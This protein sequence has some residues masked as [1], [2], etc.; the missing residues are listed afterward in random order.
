MARD[1]PRLDLHLQNGVIGILQRAGYCC[2]SCVGLFLLLTLIS[3]LYEGAVEKY[4]LL[5]GLT[6]SSSSNASSALHYSLEVKFAS[7]APHQG[8]LP[9]EQSN[10]AKIGKGDKNRY[11]FSRYASFFS[12]G[13]SPHNVSGLQQSAV[14]EG[15]EFAS[16]ESL[17]PALSAD[18]SSGDDP[19]LRNAGSDVSNEISKDQAHAPIYEEDLTTEAGRDMLDGPSTEQRH[20]SVEGPQEAEVKVEVAEDTLYN[21]ALVEIPLPALKL[22][23]V[24]NGTKNSS[25]SILEE[26]EF[27][28]FSSPRLL[29]RRALDRGAMPHMGLMVLLML[30]ILT[31]VL[32]GILGVVA[33]QHA[34]ILGA[35]SYSVVNTYMG[36][37]VNVRR[38]LKAGFKSGIMR[39]I[40]LAI[41]HGTIRGLQCLLCIKTIFRG[42]LEMEQME[43]LILRLSLMP[44][45]LLA[46]FKDKDAVNGE[47]AFRIGTFLIL[48]YIFDAIAYSVYIVA[49]WVTILEP[50]NSG[51]SALQRSW[52]LVKS[53]ELQVLT[54]K[55]LEAILCGR[56]CRWVL[57]QFLGSVLSAVLISGAQIYF[58]VVWL[59]LYFS[60]RYK[61]DGSSSFSHGVLEDFL[62]KHK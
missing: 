34:A 51:L 59:I 6:I 13:R 42:A 7:T 41:L 15:L 32:A 1:M 25:E 24:G 5:P 46:P 10:V 54:I 48:D 38:A 47:M 44:F 4:A 18:T 40:W 55:L 43:S 26:D 11:I 20:D 53:M 61:H 27:L 62:D 35:V 23:Y 39:L 30:L 8:K 49:C 31:G 2:R 19:N 29:G 14:P 37:R 22:K 9:A 45:S 58:T 57:Q 60:A 21:H 50:D 33:F 28:G 36:K 16:L 52:K 12:S 17:D 56:S 3:A